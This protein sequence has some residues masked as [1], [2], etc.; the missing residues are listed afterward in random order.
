[1]Q[2]LCL[3]LVYV[4]FVFKN[5]VSQPPGWRMVDRF[6]GFRY[7]IFGQNIV[8]SGFAEA[9]QKEADRIGCFGWIQFSKVGTFV[10]EARCSKDQGPKFQTWLEKG[11]PNSNISR[12]EVHIYEDT[13]IRLHFA[14]FKI[15]DENRDTC[16]LDPPHQCPEFSTPHKDTSLKSEEL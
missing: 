14:Y 4:A 11:M 15:L 8:T 16:F 5:V 12:M 3:I 1:M 13:K 2:L 9:V 7:E 6:Y 10:G